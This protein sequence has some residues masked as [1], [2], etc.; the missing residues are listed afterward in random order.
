MNSLQYYDTN[1]FFDEVFRMKNI[2]S[3]N[4]DVQDPICFRGITKWL[5]ESKIK[6]ANEMICTKNKAK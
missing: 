5:N 6:K 4:L 3:D 1:D 2:K